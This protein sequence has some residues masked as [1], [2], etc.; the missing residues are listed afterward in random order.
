MPVKLR[1]PK[2]RTNAA[3]DLAAWSMLFESGHDFFGDLGLPDGEAS[4]AAPE[5]WQ[6]L[7]GTFLASRPENAARAV[8]WALK[9]LG[10]PRCR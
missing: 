6:R 8:P 2:R 9:A 3:A 10:E 5:A 4:A 1:H 7:G